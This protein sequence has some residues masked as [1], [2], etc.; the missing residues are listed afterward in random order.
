MVKNAAFME[1]LWEIITRLAVI[2]IVLNGE[3]Y[4]QQELETFPIAVNTGSFNDFL[5]SLHVANPF[6][7]AITVHLNLGKVIKTAR[8]RAGLREREALKINLD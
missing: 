5:S 1:C 7:I 4:L 3:K 6:L 8:K 2:S